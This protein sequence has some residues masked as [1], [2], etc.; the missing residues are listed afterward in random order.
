MVLNGRAV[1][2]T[3]QSCWTG[4]SCNHEVKV[5]GGMRDI[6]RPDFCSPKFAGGFTELAPTQ[7]RAGSVTALARLAQAGCQS[8]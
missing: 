8:T 3:S 2:I 4:D 7:V 1:T 5:P 6:L